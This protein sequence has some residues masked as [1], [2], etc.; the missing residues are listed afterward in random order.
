MMLMY[1][2]HLAADLKGNIVHGIGAS[3]NSADERSISAQ[4]QPVL[5]ASVGF[6]SPSW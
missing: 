4:T 5:G 6:L 2:Y 3:R 1:D